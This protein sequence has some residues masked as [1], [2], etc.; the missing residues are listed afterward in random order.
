MKAKLI[1]IMMLPFGFAFSQSHKAGTLSIQ[2][3]YE[4][5]F[6][7]TYSETAINGTV[8]SK[9]T[10]SAVVTSFGVGVH[11]S[12]AEFISAGIYGNYGSY[13]ENEDNVTSTGNHFVNFGGAVRVYPVNSDHF[14]WFLGGRVGY[15]SLAINRTYSSLVS[16][17]Y[18]YGGAEYLG[19]TGVNWYFLNFIGVNVSL[20]YQYRKFDLKSYSLN[21]NVQSMNNTTNFLKASG[22]GFSAGV[23]LKIN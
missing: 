1:L 4:M 13:I 9:D 22:L 3:D 14:N 12:L 5:G 10:S 15:S 17:D 2:G 16:I 19:E 8:M 20:N 11:Y 18:T 21:S 7:G 6:M 23:S